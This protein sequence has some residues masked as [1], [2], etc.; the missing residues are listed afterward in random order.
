MGEDCR[1]RAAELRRI[2]PLQT[3]CLVNAAKV[4]DHHA[5]VPTEEPVELWRLTGPERN[6]YDLIVR[7]FLAGLRPPF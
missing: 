3:K 5:R 6:I 4:T 1:P 2:R 7:R